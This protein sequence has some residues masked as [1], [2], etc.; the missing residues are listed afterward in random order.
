MVQIYYGLK[1]VM[2]LKRKIV[3]KIFLVI[4]ILY[5]LILIYNYYP[6]NESDAKEHKSVTFTAD[7]FF[8]DWLRKSYDDFQGYDK[9]HEYKFKTLNPGD[10]AIIKDTIS[11]IEIY[12][13][14]TSNWTKI[15]FNGSKIYSSD[16]FAYSNEDWIPYRGDLL[17]MSNKTNPHFTIDGI[18]TNELKIG[19]TVKISLHIIRI[20]DTYEH[21]N[22]TIHM[23]GEYPEEIFYIH[24]GGYGKRLDKEYIIKI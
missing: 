20:D 17:Y 22:N 11:N 19:D 7:E 5:L 23:K 2:N 1:R 21:N 13:N 6:Q 24:P 15:S 9:Y 3:T 12:N 4:F 10:I 16:T 8:Y 18:I 14:K